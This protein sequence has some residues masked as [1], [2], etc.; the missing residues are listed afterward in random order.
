MVVRSFNRLD[1]ETQREIDTAVYDAICA[2]ESLRRAPYSAPAAF[3]CRPSQ[4]ARRKATTRYAACCAAMAALV[5]LLT[6]GT[7]TAQGV[8]LATAIFGLWM[9]LLPVGGAWMRSEYER[10]RANQ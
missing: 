6:W 5:A 9:A 2:R 10:W 1:T 8:A 7:A 3:V 4:S